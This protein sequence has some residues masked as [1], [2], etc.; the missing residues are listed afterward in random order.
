[1]APYRIRYVYNSRWNPVASVSAARAHRDVSAALADYFSVPHKSFGRLL[2]PDIVLDT[3]GKIVALSTNLL[4]AIEIYVKTLVIIEGR[5]FE[6]VHNLTETYRGIVEPTRLDIKR[7]Y[8]ERKSQLSPVNTTSIF[9]NDGQN[10]TNKINE[11]TPETLISGIDKEYTR[12][13]YRFDMEQT[14]PPNDIPFAALLNLC[15]AIDDLIS[16][17]IFIEPRP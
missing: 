2:T 6:T 11:R 14:K 8:E 15:N 1:M 13:R 3:H 4:F 5:E 9:L 12:W 17:S 7:R 10:Q 16:F